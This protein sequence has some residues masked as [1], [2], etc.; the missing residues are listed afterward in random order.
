MM[1]K[2]LQSPRSLKRN[3][4]L[5]LFISLGLSLNLISTAASAQSY[6][7]RTVKIL[8][9]ALLLKAFLRL[10]NNPSLLKIVLVLVA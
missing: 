6:P 7:N 8:L 4:I 1:Q 5:S 9:V 10:G 2:I 3:L